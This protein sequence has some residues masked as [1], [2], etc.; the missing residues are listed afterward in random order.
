MQAKTQNQQR[1][2]GECTLSGLITGSKK[3]TV[4]VRLDMRILPAY[5][6]TV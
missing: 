6:L 5:S 4:E 1:I 3:H 2:I